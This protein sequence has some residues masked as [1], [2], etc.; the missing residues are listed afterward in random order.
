MSWESRQVRLAASIAA[1]VTIGLVYTASPL[2][3]L[4]IALFPVVAWFAVRG[5]HASDA[6][7][8][9]I[10][11]TAGFAV[12]LAVIAA[13]FVSGIPLHNDLSVGALTGDEAYNVSRAL[14]ARDV[15][16]GMATSK[17]DYVIAYDEYGRSSYLTFLTMLQTLLG[18]APFGIK[19][20]NA[21]LFIV[22]A[23]LLYRVVRRAYGALPAAMGLAV[24]L[25]IPTL[26][27]S[28]T[29]T[30]KE[31]AYFLTT[32]ACLVGFIAI[33][34]AHSLT[35]RVAAAAVL[36]GGL[37]ILSDLR[38]AGAGLAIAGLGVGVVSY[39]MMQTTPRRV[40]AAC[41][42]TVALLAVWLVPSVNARVIAGVTEAAKVHSGHVF[43]VGHSYQ[44]LDPGFYYTPAAPSASSLALTDDH[45]ARFLIRSAYTFVLTPLPWEMRSR[46][47]LALLP[48]Q[49]LW[50]FILLCLPAG[51]IAGWRRDRL[52]TALLIGY[53][54]PT[55]VV[56]AVTNGNVGTLVRLRG[57]I[58][59]YLLWVSALGC[60][61][62]LE[63]LAE[64]RA[65]A[66]P[67][68]PAL[69]ALTRASY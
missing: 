63:R 11:L 3:F 50:Y 46:S 32:A 14:R 16:L 53:V 61:V 27:Y 37:W 26:L 40:I 33:I 35:G 17:Y 39:V 36:I 7:T 42:V 21:L 28:S 23:V 41:V 10:I 47:E 34:R 5:F 52:V 56:L 68:S 9:L 45:A 19:A 49:L 38:R 57:L 24:L 31:S 62:L 12:R 60:C 48:E 4:A 54:L 64:R 51:L 13:L 6:R 55:A 43:T 22:G 69:D 15:L 1:G 30:L 59:P 67:S 2:S 25:F 20:L 44:L 58:T 65:A 66:T 18:P 8:I 29:S